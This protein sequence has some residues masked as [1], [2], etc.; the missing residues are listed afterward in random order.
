MAR[1]QSLRQHSAALNGNVPAATTTVR[2]ELPVA[3]F[4]SPSSKR[5]DPPSRSP[6]IRSSPRQ[7]PGK[8]QKNKETSSTTVEPLVE[9]I[10]EHNAGKDVA[11][12][13][14]SSCV[15][16][17]DESIRVLRPRKPNGKEVVNE[18]VDPNG[19]EED[20][21]AEDRTEEAKHLD[22]GDDD[23]PTPV[24]K[25]LTSVERLTRGR[26]F[27]PFSPTGSYSPTHIINS[28]FI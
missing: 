18:V 10:N 22:S 23:L 19:S 1:T 9:S 2:S 3:P 20:S 13:H 5:K 15:D 26:Q 11:P 6:G 17:V 28:C 16:E 21:V 12:S 25:R 14:G 27:K 8:I 4:P 24:K 7:S